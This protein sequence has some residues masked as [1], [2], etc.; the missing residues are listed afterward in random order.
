MSKIRTLRKDVLHVE[1]LKRDPDAKQT[2]AFSEKQAFFTIFQCGANDCKFRVL[3]SSAAIIL[4]CLQRQKSAL[5][6][7]HALS[8]SREYHTGTTRCAR[9]GRSSVWTLYYL[10]LLR[11]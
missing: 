8:C 6:D 4:L 2:H 10:L 1:R 7:A 11:V 9:T 5:V 3:G